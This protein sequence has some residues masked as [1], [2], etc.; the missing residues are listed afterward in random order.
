MK[1]ICTTE[2]IKSAVLVAERFTSRHI[3]LPILSHILCRADEKKISLIATNLEVGVEYQVAGKVQKPGSATIPAKQFS[4]LLASLQE[5]TVTLDGKSNQLTLH[6]PTSDVTILG[7]DASDFPNLPSIKKEHSFSLSTPELL[8]AL[9]VVVPA[10]AT[11]DIKP[12]LSGVLIALD[13]NTLT[14]A[15]TDSFRLAEK[16]IDDIAGVR[17]RLECILPIRTAQE[18]MRTLPADG[19]DDVQVII[20]E[21]QVVFAWGSVRILSRLID[22][23]YPPYQNIIPSSF[24]T[25]LL[26]N[27]DDLLK[28]I[29][30]AAVFSSRLNDVT[31]RFSPTELEV[32]TQNAETGST[33]ARL[34][35]KGRGASGSTVFNYRYLSDG[36]NAAGGENVLLNLNG[37]SGPTLI[38]NPGDAS[39]R[40]L[41]MPIRSV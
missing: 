31:L 19:D 17:E 12:E 21:H 5:E 38:Q 37:V 32:A 13:Q 35:A 24:E 15:A 10:A 7:L 25:T 16:K 1:I 8:S 3:T 22:G 29:R 4:Q 27:R 36:L 40:Y 26:V 20:G 11:S 23:A 2:N 33:R 28:K 30:L 6:T 34:S 14:L 18:V 39:Y 41:V 9:E